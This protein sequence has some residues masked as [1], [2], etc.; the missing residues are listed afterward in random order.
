MVDS[1][2]GFEIGR[3]RSPPRRKLE[4]SSYVNCLNIRDFEKGFEIWK[5]ISE[6]NGSIVSKGSNI[7]G[8]F[9]YYNFEERN[10]PPPYP[11]AKG[12]SKFSLL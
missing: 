4:T 6:Y 2:N 7:M 12:A 11:E 5:E 8:H 10:F 1:K 3:K 9:Y